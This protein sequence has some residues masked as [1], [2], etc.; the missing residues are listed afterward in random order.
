MRK[1]QATKPE[2]EDRHLW[3]LV[4]DT[5]TPLNKRRAEELKSQM[6]DFLGEVAAPTP[7]PGPPTVQRGPRPASYHLPQAQPHAPKPQTRQSLH[8]HPIEEPVAK[9]LAKGRLPIDSRIDLHGMTQDRARFALLDFLQMSQRAGDRIV[10]VIT[11]KGSS[12]QGVL[13]QN[14]PQWLTLHPFAGLVNGFR[15]SHISHGGEGALYVRLRKP[16]QRR[17]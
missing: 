10:L 15:T 2:L 17:P 7:A 8:Q 14:V 11:G 12:G 13:R 16:R 1:R 4:S 9:K 5:V 3:K 6:A